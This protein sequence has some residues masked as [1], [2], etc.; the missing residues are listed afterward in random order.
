MRGTLK[1]FLLPARGKTDA[2]Q[3]QRAPADERG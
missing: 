3:Q 1:A 2:F